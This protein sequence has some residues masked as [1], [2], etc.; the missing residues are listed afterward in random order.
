[1]EY[2]ERRKAARKKILFT[3][4]ITEKFLVLEVSTIGMKILSDFRLPPGLEVPF[5]L[6]LGEESLPIIAESMWCKSVTE[7]EIKRYEVGFRFVKASSKTLH[8][9]KRYLDEALR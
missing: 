4:E 7:G 1:M 9:I 5:R 8:I 2:S 6:Y 3:V